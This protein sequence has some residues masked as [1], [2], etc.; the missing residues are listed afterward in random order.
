MRGHT[1][2]RTSPVCKLVAYAVLQVYHGRRQST[3]SS[4]LVWPR[5]GRCA[6]VP[7]VRGQVTL[8]PKF[9]PALSCCLFLPALTFRSYSPTAGQ[10]TPADGVL[11]F[12]PRV[13]LFE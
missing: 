5:W 8:R 9:S 10:L 6:E 4:L 7:P 3:S 1:V 13:L 2:L 12:V 11:L